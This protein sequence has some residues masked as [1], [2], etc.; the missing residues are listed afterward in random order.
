[1][2]AHLDAQPRPFSFN[3]NPPG[4]VYLLTDSVG[5]FCDG[6]EANGPRCDGAPLASPPQ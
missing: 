5:L 1:V 4:A 2:A 6:F 3:V